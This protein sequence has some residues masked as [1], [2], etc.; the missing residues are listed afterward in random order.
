MKIT[1]EKLKQIVKEEL[2][3]LIDEEG[4]SNFFDN[5][6][7]KKERCKGKPK[8]GDC[9]ED[10]PTKKQW[11]DITSEQYYH[12]ADA[13]YDDGTI[14]E[15]L[16][17]WDDVLEEAEYQG[18]KVT[19]NKPMQGDVK[20]SKVYVRKSAFGHFQNPNIKNGTC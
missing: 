1:K 2:N 7:K 5:M 9:A 20:K 11:K 15:D 4:N 19:L 18:R 13:T 3:N 8:T 14:V 17:F 12:I 16:E 10:R 6:R